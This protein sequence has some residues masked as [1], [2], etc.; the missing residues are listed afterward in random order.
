MC[1]FYKYQQFKFKI[2]FF[3]VNAYGHMPATVF[4]PLKVGIK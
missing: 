1:V 2:F 4:T 3:Q